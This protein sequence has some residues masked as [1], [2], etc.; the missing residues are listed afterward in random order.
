[1]KFFMFKQDLRSDN[2]FSSVLYTSWV[3]ASIFILTC[4]DNSEL[5][6]ILLGLFVTLLTI[7]LLRYVGYFNSL[8]PRPGKGDIFSVIVIVPLS[9]FLIHISYFIL[10]SRFICSFTELFYTSIGIAL[11]S[12]LA[13][14]C[15]AGI[16]KQPRKRKIVL[17]LLPEEREQLI[18]DITDNGYIEGLKF[19]DEE[20]LKKAILNDSVNKISLIVISQNAV[21]NFDVDGMLLRAHLEGVSI[22][23]YQNLETDITGRVKIKDT[24]QWAYVL[25]ATKQTILLR[26]YRK[27]KII[28]EPIIATFLITVLSPI[29]LLIALLI[30]LNS[31][32]PVFYKQTRTGYL[33]KDFTLIKFRSMYVN[34]EEAGPQWSSGE[35]DK[36]VTSI[37]NFLRNTRLDELPQ[38]INVIRGEM[39]F[40]GPRPERPEIYQK[41]K[42]EIPLFKMR[43]LILPGITGWAQVCAGY[44][45]SVAESKIKLEYDLY[46]IKRMT[47]RLDFVITIKT[48]L[49]AIFGD[50][51]K[52][53]KIGNEAI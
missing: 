6:K 43:T 13:D 34:A 37:G 26:I 8:K 29:M 17:D 41:L 12:Y 30:K 23:D 35:K 28:F 49:V 11:V 48:I 20:D 3:F 10:T 18:T 44:A 33:G 51:K 16:R 15:F 46:Y 21:S 22:V 9:T 47:P 42:D 36:R 14:F 32:G 53:K 25:E 24:D 19:L 40:F 27:I 1:M 52:D 31:K 2:C 45:A 4:D 39:G 7:T 5:I 50:N 38:L